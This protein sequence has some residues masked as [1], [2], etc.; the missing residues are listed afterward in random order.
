MLPAASVHA[1]QGCKCIRFV[2]SRFGR[3]LISAVACSRSALAFALALAESSAAI[4]PCRA[5]SFVNLTSWA[6]LVAAEPDEA[7]EEPRA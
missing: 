1:R 5:A 7:D 3:N 2:Q 4:G 6:A